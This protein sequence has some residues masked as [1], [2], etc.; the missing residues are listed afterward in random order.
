LGLAAA[1]ALLLGAAAAVLLR[2]HAAALKSVTLLPEPR[3]VADFS[4]TGSD[5]RPFTR[6]SLAGHW[7]LIY[8]GYT[9]CPDQCPTTLALLKSVYAK[10]GAV[11][12]KIQVL[13]VSIDPERD[14]P[15]RLAQYVHYFSPQFAAATGPQSELDKMGSN[16][17]FVYD[18]V[19]GATPQSYLMDHSAAL[20]LI[21]PDARLAGYLTPP[22]NAIDMAADL[23][24]LAGD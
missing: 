20:M 7:T 17:G 23:K 5:G 6:A 24:K 18:K 3:A 16:L 21:D 15:A 8:V 9:F 14:T 22:F 2:P 4:L 1:A 12:G 19:P 11:A 13:F 10:L